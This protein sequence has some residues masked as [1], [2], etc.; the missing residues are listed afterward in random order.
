MIYLATIL[1]IVSFTL[2]FRYRNQRLAGERKRQVVQTWPRT[3]ATFTS[4]VPKANPLARGL[5]PITDLPQTEYQYTVRSTRYIGQYLSP[6]GELINSSTNERALLQ[7]QCA[8]KWQIYYNPADPAE[9]YLS[10]GPP[11]IQ[12]I[13]LVLD[14]FFLI[15]A[16]AVMIFSWYGILTYS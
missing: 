7:L 11:R 9:A 3:V 16:P 10:P 13:H 2:A 12:N 5:F 4:K 6:A 1:F 8:D 15:F 14:F